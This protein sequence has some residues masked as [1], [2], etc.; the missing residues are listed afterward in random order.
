VPACAALVLCT[1]AVARSTTVTT[2]KTKRG[3]DLAADTGHTLYMFTSDKP[4]RSACGGACA[5]VWLPLL[6]SGRPAAAKGSGVNGKLLG[7]IKRSGRV[8]QV[9]YNRH[10]LYLFARD[11]Q[12]GQINGEGTHQYGGRWYIINKAG[13]PVKPKASGGI[14][15]NPICQGY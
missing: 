15:C 12:P 3:T 14:V 4:G 9:T 1:V 13:N 10:P 2:H 5:D 6:T 7:T 8:L 11:K